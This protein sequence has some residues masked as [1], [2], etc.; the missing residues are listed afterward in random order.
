MKKIIIIALSFTSQNIYAYGIDG[1]IAEM[2][3][4]DR[5][6]IQ[7]NGFIINNKILNDIKRK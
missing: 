7:E 3:E 4:P 6:A 2:Y 1:N 5:S